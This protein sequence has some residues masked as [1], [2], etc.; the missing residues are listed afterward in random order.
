MHHA[1]ARAR[2]LVPLLALGLGLDASTAQGGENAS[3]DTFIPH[4]V[5]PVTIDGGL[6]WF[7][8]ATNGAPTNATDLTYS[9]DLVLQAPLSKHGKAVVALEAG[10]G[11][12][13]DSVIHP[14]SITNYDAYNTHVTSASPDGSQVVTPS[15]SQAYYEGEYLDHRLVVDL[16]KL[17][18]HAAYD[19][20]AYANDETNQFLSGLFTRSAGSAF[21]ELDRY[22]APGAALTYGLSPLI[23]LTLVA[24]NGNGTGFNDVFDYPYL[25]GQINFKPNLAGREGNYRF[26]A[27]SDARH[28]VYTKIDGGGFTSNSAWGLSFDQPLTHHVGLFARWSQQ[29]DSVTENVAKGSWS[30]GTALAGGLWGRESDTVGIGYGSILLN[31][32]ADPGTVL[33]LSHTGD[34]SHFEAYYKFGVSQHITL[35]A[36]VQVLQNL[37]GNADADTVTVAG[38]RGQLN[39]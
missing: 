11:A 15:V 18:V 29:D 25:V 14:L 10:E 36:D 17:D 30:V 16:G 37:G 5:G 21:P 23:E 26:Y 38:I 9:L 19:N 6:T 39:F 2:A 24:A 1:S 28:Q 34:E 20:N 4:Q 12:G 7:L 8:Q 27:I 31:G 3:S 33:G 22:Y 35:T 32:K 13:V